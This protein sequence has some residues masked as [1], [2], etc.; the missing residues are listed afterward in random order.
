MKSLMPYVWVGIGGF[1]G[2][3]ARY[4]VTNLA[5]WALGVGFPYGT[6]VI[7][8]SGSFLLGLLL[9]LVAH[10]VIPH[11]QELRLAVA[12]GF[13]GAYTT[14]STFEYDCHA[15]L[16][17]GEWVLAAVNMLGSLALG[18]VAVRV[19]VVAAKHWP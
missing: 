5:R 1:A 14:F 2:A 9:T 3:N 4:L 18:L 17:D 19:G 15:L 7:N 8:V 6:F 11:G 10:R 13:L 12:V 16:E